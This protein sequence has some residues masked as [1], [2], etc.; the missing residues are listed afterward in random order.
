MI[1]TIGR[2][3]TK[4]RALVFMIYGLL[5]AGAVTT[6]YP[7]LL[8]VAGS[9]KSAVDESEAT[10]IPRFLFD[11]QVLWTKHVEG[12]TNESVGLI[13]STFNVQVEDF[14]QLPLSS[15][16]NEPFVDEW[17]AFLEQAQ[18]PSEYYMIGYI[19][20]PRGSR[21]VVPHGMRA[22]KAELSRR[23]GGDLSRL[24]QAMGTEFKDW[25]AFDVV[26]EVNLERYRKSEYTPLPMALREFKMRQGYGQRLY[27]SIDGFYRHYLISQ[28]T[29]D[30]AAYNDAHGTQYESYFR[31]HL[32]RRLPAAATH[33][34]LQREDWQRFVRVVL[35]LAWM[36]AD[37]ESAPIYR[38]FLKAKYGKLER[39]NLQYGT[40]YTSYAKIPLIQE[41][42]RGG[43]ALSDW[44]LFVQGWVDPE[45]GQTHMLPIE[46]IRIHSTDFMFRDYLMQRHRT[47]EVLNA[48]M[49]TL[50]YGWLDV[51]PPQRDAHQ[52]IFE[53]NKASLRWEFLVRNYLTVIDYMMLHGRGVLNTVIYCSLAVLLAL[54]VNPLAAYALSRYKPPSAYKIL[55]LLM[56][57]MAFP[58]M[59]TQIPVF[60]MLRELSLLNTFWALVLPGLASGYSIF[61]LKGFFDSLPGELY[62]SAALDGAGEFRI[63]WQITMSLSKPVLAVIA[64]GAFTSAYSNFMFALLICQDQQMWTLMV[65][66]YQLQQRAS[67]GVIYASL[68]VA[69]IPTFVIFI[70]CQNIIMRGIVVPVER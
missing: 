22:F 64:L 8:M 44:D 6:V 36:R 29:R 2:R 9:T 42:P 47:I 49:K 70:L 3:S 66:L 12:L 67:M 38:A 35:N 59:V 7:F 34:E 4:V 57:T 53:Q 69:A 65:W 28:Y 13:S 27:P 1:S 5:I 56:L 68:I 37:P 63:F 18:L 31:I 30:V 55:L 54:L 24:N 25:R 33:N 46:M 10:L 23:F 52:K 51:V 15:S 45:T 11:D 21:G 61:L 48:T 19:H 26:P 40:D 32:D 39:L 62:E 20:V 14:S 58:P 16:T 50:F 43:A 60:L 17:H 41:L